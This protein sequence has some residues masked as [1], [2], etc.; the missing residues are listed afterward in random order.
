MAKTKRSSPTRTK[1]PP[2]WQPIPVTTTL[3]GSV[4]PETPEEI[5]TRVERQSMEWFHQTLDNL[6]LM[7]LGREDLKRAFVA[8]ARDLDAKLSPRSPAAL[9]ALAVH[10]ALAV[11]E[12]GDDREAVL[13]EL[14]AWNRRVHGGAVVSPETMDN[15]VTDALKRIPIKSLPS[16]THAALKNRV[17]RGKK[18]KKLRKT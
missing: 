5:A 13:K 17:R 16:W 2:A 10:Y 12:H 1:K 14:V 7:A 4:P 6:W 9:Q 3:L 18:I 11:E 15:R 8:K